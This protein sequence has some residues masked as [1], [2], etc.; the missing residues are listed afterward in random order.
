MKGDLMTKLVVRLLAGV[1]QLGVVAYCALLAW[2]MGAWM[3]DDR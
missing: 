1:A 3:V 2:L